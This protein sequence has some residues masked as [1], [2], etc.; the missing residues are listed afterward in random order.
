MQLD[1]STR[2]GFDCVHGS[3]GSLD[4]PLLICPDSAANVRFLPQTIEEGRQRRL[5]SCLIDLAGRTRSSKK[6]RELAERWSKEVEKVLSK[7]YG[8]YNFRSDENWIRMYATL[9]Y[10]SSRWPQGVSCHNFIKAF[11]KFSPSGL[12][13]FLLQT[14]RRRRFN[15]PCTTH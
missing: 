6:D 14:G 4:F 15:R 8:G 11:E 9:S 13:A 3:R 1:L 5:K 2:R 7:M 12:T 10:I